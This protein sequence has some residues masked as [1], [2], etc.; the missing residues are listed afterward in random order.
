MGTH[1]ILAKE[2]AQKAVQDLL[3]EVSLKIERL[4]KI[5]SDLDSYKS[6]LP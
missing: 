5:R 3:M 1:A 4:K 2:R 6:E